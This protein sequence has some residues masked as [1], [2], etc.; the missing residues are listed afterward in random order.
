M[1]PTAF[2]V[3]R[4]EFAGWFARAGLEDALIEWHNANSWRGFARVPD[5]PE[6]SSDAAGT[7]AASAGWTSG[8][9]A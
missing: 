4:D 7:A 3:R 5:G 1:A 8:E 6:A 2:Y 9:H